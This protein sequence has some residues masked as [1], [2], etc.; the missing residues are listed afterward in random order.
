MEQSEPRG[1]E[2]R[3]LSTQYKKKCILQCSW[4]YWRELSSYLGFKILALKSRDFYKQKNFIDFITKKIIISEN[5]LF[6]IRKNIFQFILLEHLRIKVSENNIF[7]SLDNVDF[8]VNNRANCLKLENT[9]TTMALFF[10]SL[11]KS[12]IC[13]RAAALLG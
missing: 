13:D 1:L 3:T 7:R 5:N 12:G 4:F 2:S 11:T 10:V 9:E 6:C 8:K